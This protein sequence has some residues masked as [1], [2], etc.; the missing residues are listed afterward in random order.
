[1]ARRDKSCTLLP[2]DV[3][4]RTPAAALKKTLVIQ[5]EKKV[6]TYQS[7]QTQKNHRAAIASRAIVGALLALPFLG[8]A[9][10]L[11][12][13]KQIPD[14]LKVPPGNVLLL[15]ADGR[16]T[17]KYTCPVSATSNATPHAI[18]RVGRHEGDLVAI[19]FGG[20]TWQALDGSS[21][22]GDGAKAIH[23]PAPDPDGVDWLLLPAK[24]TT[25]NG[26]FSRVTFIQRLFT[27]G[28]K[29]PAAG[30]QPGQTEVLVEYSAQYLFY[31]P[32]AR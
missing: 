10:V 6:M 16:G 32:A 5:L 3:W 31:V 26:E 2:A 21:V 14:K 22:V 18:L 28:G 25:G 15:Q 27:D 30:C 20:P 12:G 19:H 24:S 17:Q 29:P 4:R 7:A 11:A 13:S 8:A 1:M 9:P 23:F